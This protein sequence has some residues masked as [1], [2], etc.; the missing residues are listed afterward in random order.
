MAECFKCVT[1]V[2][3]ESCI[4]IPQPAM[5]IGK[6]ADPNSL[7]NCNQSVPIFKPDREFMTPRMS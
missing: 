4:H 7:L 3:R 1:L 5:V 6:A 2:Y